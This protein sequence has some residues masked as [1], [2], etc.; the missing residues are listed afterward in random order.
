[1][2]VAGSVLT[3]RPRLSHAIPAGPEVSTLVNGGDVVI[4]WE[5]VTGPPAGFPNRA[6]EIVGYQVIVGSFEITLPDS[7]T[8]MQLPDELIESLGPGEH[9]FEVLAIDVSG[10]QTITA[11]SFEID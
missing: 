8:S 11:G 3:S 10:N 6:I 7:A 9:G 4:S 2:T 5:P 1:V